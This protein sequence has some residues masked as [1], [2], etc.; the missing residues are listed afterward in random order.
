MQMSSYSLCSTIYTHLWPKQC[1][2]CRF[3][4]FFSQPP[5]RIFR[6]V[7]YKTI[8]I[9]RKK[10]KRKGEKVT[11]GPNDA[12]RIVWAHSCRCRPPCHIFHGVEYKTIVIKKNTREKEKR[13]SPTPHTTPEPLFRPVLIIAALYVAYYVE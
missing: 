2:W 8:V 13:N 3:G 1:V 10:H 5:C 11:Y 12:G 7:E 9:N 6:R 4:P